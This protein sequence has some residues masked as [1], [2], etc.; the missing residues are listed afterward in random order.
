[1]YGSFFNNF[2]KTSSVN[3]KGLSVTLPSKIFRVN[4]HP[5]SLRFG[6]QIRQALSRL[7]CNKERGVAGCGVWGGCGKTILMVAW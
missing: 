2:I 1:M 6:K 7:P 4:A 5:L 3:I